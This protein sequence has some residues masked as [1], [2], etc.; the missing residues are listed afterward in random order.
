MKRALVIGAGLAL[1]CAVAYLAWL[2]PARVELHLTPSY[3]VAPPLAAALAFAFLAGAALVLGGFGLLGAGRSLRRWWRG[4]RLRRV[5]RADN[6][7]QAGEALLWEGDSQRARTLLLRS[8][9]RDPGHQ[10]ALLAAAASHLTDGEPAAAERLLREALAQRRGDPELLLSLSDAC[11]RQGDHAGAI[12]A[13]EQV[14]ARHPNAAHVLAALRE[15]YVAAER[16]SEALASQS[17]YL[18]SLSQPALLVRERQRLLGLQYEAALALPAPAERSAALEQLVDAH[19]TFVPAL[20]SLGDALADCGLSPQAVELWQ[21]ALRAVPRTIL[22]ERLL[23]HAG[24]GRAREQCAHALRKARPAS[25]RPECVRL[26]Q[27]QLRL[28]SATAEETMRELDAVAASMGATAMFRRLRADALRQLGHFEQ[29]LDE[30]AAAAASPAD[31][32]CC[33][34]CRQT[35]PAWSGRCRHCASWDSY[36]AAVEIAAD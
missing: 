6:L 18:R 16:W 20:V 3:L 14:R 21:R 1:V 36:R 8:W 11:A 33:R 24:D 25:V 31:W 9:R 22:V 26:W 27:L 23:R 13:L 32:F 15:Q 4:R 35:T 30:Y 2:N 12:Q 17:L 5:A 34:S 29:A 19:P 7:A 10:R 28:S